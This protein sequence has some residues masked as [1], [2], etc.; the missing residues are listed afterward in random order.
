MPRPPVSLALLLALPA[1]GLAAPPPVVVS[2]EARA[3]H[4]AMPVVD[5]HNDLPWTLR[6]RADSSFRNVDLT[7]P[8]PQFHTDIPRLRAGGVGAQFWSAY[9]PSSTAKKGTAVPTTLEQIDVIH[10][11]IARYPADM[12]LATTVADIAAAKKA[13][14]IAGL[15]GLEGGHSIDNSLG[16]LRMLLQA[17]ASAT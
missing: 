6:T 8:Q 16:A 2:A 7:R 9:V 5:G 3:I 12:A 14:K 10:R 1:A 13:G 11:M 4:A 17:S 15:I